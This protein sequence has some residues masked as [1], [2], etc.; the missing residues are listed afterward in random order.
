[1]K[2]HLSSALKIYLTQKLNLRINFCFSSNYT[3]SPVSSSSH[4]FLPHTLAHKIKTK[5]Q[6]H[7]EMRNQLHYDKGTFHQTAK[8]NAEILFLM[9]QETFFQQKVTTPT[10]KTPTSE[11]FH[12]DDLVDLLCPL[13]LCAVLY[14]LVFTYT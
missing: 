12:T 2:Q 6:E 11:P 3:A 7:S 9:W 4:N 5:K 13:H 10:H 1:M 14:G 8:Q